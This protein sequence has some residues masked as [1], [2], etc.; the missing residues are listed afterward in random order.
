MW[1]CLQP[2][3]MELYFLWHKPDVLIPY[4]YRVPLHYLFRTVFDRID[5]V[6]YE[7]WNLDGLCL[8]ERRYRI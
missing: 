8:L 2:I 7:K 4:S 3:F 6:L 1:F 5:S